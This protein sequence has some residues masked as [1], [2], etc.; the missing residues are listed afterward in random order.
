MFKQF[1]DS[2][3]KE[4]NTDL[5]DAIKSDNVAVIDVRTKAEYM[6]S[7]MEGSINI[8]L[9]EIPKSVD[10]IKT[11]N[12]TVVLCCASGNRSGQATRFLQ[13][14]GLTDVHNGGSWTEVSNI[15]NQ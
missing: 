5:I 4:E 14:Q 3:K 15:K 2:F 9:D 8:P 7:H 10:T 13:G 6:N 11:M 12:K 1:F